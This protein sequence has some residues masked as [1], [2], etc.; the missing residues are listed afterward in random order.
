MAGS[1]STG[2]AQLRAGVDVLLAGSLDELTGVEIADLLES[3]EVQRRRLEAVDAR[4]VAAIEERGVAGEFG[5]TSTVDLLATRLRVDSREAKH[6]VARARVLGPRRTLTG[7]ALPSLLPATAEALAA[8]EVSGAHATV[9]AATLDALDHLPTAAEIAGP[10]ENFLVD[11]ARQ[12]SP[13]ALDRTAAL[14]LARLDPEGVEPRETAV[15]RR[16]GLTIVT[17]PDRGGAVVSGRLTAKCAA[18][19]QTI[20]DALSAPAPADNGVDERS[21]TQRRH[22]GFLEAGLRILRSGSL[23]DCGGVPVTVL[24]TTSEEEL[25]LPGGLART[26]H[27]GLVSVDRLLGLAEIEIN[28]VRFSTT[29]E[30]LS[31]GRERRLAQPAQR[32]ALA[33]RDGGC[34]FPSCTRPA[35]W[36]Q[37]H[38]IVSW[39]A[40]GRTD[41]DNL[42]LVCTHH[43]RLLDRGDWQVRMSRDGVP[44]WIP[45]PWL[46]PRQR[47]MRNTANHLSDI[48]FD[49]D[50][51]TAMPGHR[52]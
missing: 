14:T 27:G 34:C 8:G 13:R 17:T 11:A 39:L 51:G 44:E 25:H 4:V 43:H 45:P 38:H 26:A 12:E 31:L 15:V 35:A 7:D 29:G 5:R 1:M 32:R 6:R 48:P 42:C 36:T 28:A 46:D 49:I 9:I 18:V 16:R 10:V 50:V 20:V 33:A 40:G 47:P 21:A 22:D 2:L 37:A 23:P 30:V 52:R 24:V 41:I 19:W 3:L